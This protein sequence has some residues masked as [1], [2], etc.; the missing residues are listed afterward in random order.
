M[1]FNA[2]VCDVSS[3]WEALEKMLLHTHIF[4]IRQMRHLA[5]SQVLGAAITTEMPG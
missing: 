4:N 2:E 5:C 1:N 3:R